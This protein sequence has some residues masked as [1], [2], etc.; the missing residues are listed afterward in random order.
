VPTPSLVVVDG[1]VRTQAPDRTAEAV[2]FH[3]G[4][5]LAVGATEEID[6][7]AG[8]ETHRLDAEGRVVLPGFVDCHTHAAR[9]GE[10]RF[11]QDMSNA[12]GK[13]EALQVLNARAQKTPEDGWVIGWNWDETAW[14]GEGPITPED[15]DG[16]SPHHKVL[17][18]RVC[19]HRIVVNQAALDAL[20][21]D[22][23]TPGIETD[24]D[25]NITGRLSEDA[26]VQAWE[27]CAPA[28]ETCVKGLK[29]ETR[30]LAEMG[31][32][33]VADTAGRREIRMLTQAA[34]EGWML[35]RSGLYVK[36]DLLEHLEGLAMGPLSGPWCSLLG[37][38]I[39]VDG[40]IGAR[41]AALREPYADEDTRGE[42]LHAP[43]EI[44]DVA[45]RAADLGLQLK[46]HAIGDRAIDAVL[47]GLAQADVDPA[48][49]PRREHVEMLHD[50]QLDRMR[51]LGVTAVMQPNFVGNWQQPGG[52]YE[53]AL[54]GERARRMNPF[55]SVLD[56]DVPLA[57]SSDGMP[58]GPLYGIACAVDHPNPDE[59]LTVPEGIRSYTRNAAYALGDEHARGVLQEGALGDA[60]V[61]DEDPRQ[62][63]AIDEIDVH[64][65]VVGGQRIV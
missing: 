47:D 42:L 61:L 4:R 15:L 39:Y 54:G 37:V 7:L 60:V 59:A 14:S 41:T 22:R 13:D 64:A 3:K 48:L 65:T 33:S 8:P 62:A 2:A 10:M 34:Q 19:G 57:F 20:D 53:Q 38:K 49:R 63:A 12:P 25:G 24:E 58:Y 18:R 31:I 52:L 17:A 55:R 5:V 43:E 40:S 1:T 35:Q 27:A 45:S 56:A 23:S 32:T 6:A 44:A 29:L 9:L 30:R 50:D 26:A 28:H 16:V 46:A 11:R 51:E 36:D 21:L